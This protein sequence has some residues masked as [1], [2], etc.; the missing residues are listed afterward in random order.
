MQ[1]SATR[2]HFLR[3]SSNPAA[4]PC[5]FSVRW[6]SI[7][8]ITKCVAQLGRLQP[9]A[10]FKVG[11]PPAFAIET[12]GLRFRLV[13]QAQLRRVQSTLVALTCWIAHHVAATSEYY[14]N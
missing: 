3:P 9:M 7:E 8:S 6:A 10:A 12:Q 11:P 2:M 4:E 5:H 1:A 14:D 13:A